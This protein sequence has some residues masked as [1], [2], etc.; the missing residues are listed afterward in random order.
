MNKIILSVLLAAGLAAC[1]RKP[2]QPDWKS[3][4]SGSLKSFS[5]LYLKG[6]TGA[7]DTEFKRARLEMAST[8]RP[9]LVA[10]AELYR[11]ATRAA[12]LE[13]DDCPLFQ[14]LAQDASPAE[15]AY[16]AYLAGKWQ[17]LDASLLPEQHRAIVQGKGGLAA[18]ADPLSQ[19]VAAGVLMQA[20]RMTPAD[21]KLA[22]DTA[23]GQG[24]RRPL[25]MWLGVAHKR[26]S[27]AGDMQEAGRIQRR[28]D[29]ALESK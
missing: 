23:S 6:E 7:A 14:A 10:H 5:E 17:G 29:L 20:G 28:I 4:A 11:C 12:S 3:N 8:G 15:R 2:V 19:L 27:A 18:V 21:I 1:G 16:A 22:T 13:Y 9:D 24:W 25:L 26:A